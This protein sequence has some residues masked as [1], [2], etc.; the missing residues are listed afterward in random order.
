MDN[1]NSQAPT[2]VEP[3][4]HT[5]AFLSSVGLDD[6]GKEALR[7]LLVTGGVATPDTDE[8]ARRSGLQAD[9]AEMERRFQEEIKP[10]LDH[11]KE[12]RD[13]VVAE[14][15][16]GAHW[17]GPDGVVYEVTERKG[18]WVEFFPFE[19]ARTRREGEAKGSLSL[20]RAR[21]LG[22]EVEGK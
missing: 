19:I 18:Q 11:F 16:V 13:L 17:Q 22:Y 7:E 12:V 2:L 10:F 9:Y 21:E 14:C 3:A 5:D 20:T 4:P 8:R 1:N 15:G 6:D